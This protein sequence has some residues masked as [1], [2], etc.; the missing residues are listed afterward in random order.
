MSVRV[1]VRVR[2]ALTVFLAVAVAPS[3]ALQ[4]EPARKLSP[5]GGGGGDVAA[6]TDVEVTRAADVHLGRIE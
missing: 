1:R 2:V 4:A 6:V 3:F 5:L